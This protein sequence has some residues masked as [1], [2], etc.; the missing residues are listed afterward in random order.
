MQF[1][2]IRG[3]H[4]ICSSFFFSVLEEMNDL[5]RNKL[6]GETREERMCL[7][8]RHEEPMKVVKLD[9]MRI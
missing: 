1:Q 8:A 7:K 4:L 2:L 9:L 5:G 3:T 6:L